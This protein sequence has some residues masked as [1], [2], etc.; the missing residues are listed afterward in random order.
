MDIRMTKEQ[1]YGLR[2]SPWSNHRSPTD[3]RDFSA[4]SIQVIQFRAT[5]HMEVET[6]DNNE[7]RRD[8]RRSEECVPTGGMSVV[9]QVLAFPDA[10]FTILK[11][12]LGRFWS[13]IGVPDV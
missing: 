10:S 9:V 7:I 8:Q 4:S 11:T 6:R 1:Q 3:S 5:C 12:T 13:N 2:V